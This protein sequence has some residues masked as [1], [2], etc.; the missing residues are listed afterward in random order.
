MEVVV[1]GEAHVSCVCLKV[2]K[3]P[4]PDLVTRLEG[5]YRPCRSC[6]SDVNQN[7]VLE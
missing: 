1:N 4:L 5:R 3:D 7:C 6:S 2:L